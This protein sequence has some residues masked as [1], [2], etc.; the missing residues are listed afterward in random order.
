MGEDVENKIKKLFV[1]T[2]FSFSRTDPEFAEIIANF[3][4]DETVKESTLIEKEQML[5]ILSV[6]LGCQGMGEFQ[7]MLYVALNTGIDPVAIKEVIYQATA[8]LGIGR[9]YDFLNAANQIMEQHGIRLPLVPQATTDENTRF[10]A[11]LDKQV[12]LFG[13]DMAKRQTN[14]PVLCRNINRWLADKAGI[15]DFSVCAKV[16]VSIENMNEIRR[17]NFRKCDIKCAEIWSREKYE[18]KSRWTPSDVKQWRK[19]NGYTWH[20]RNNMVICDLVPTK[21]NRFF[22]HL[23]GVSECKKCRLV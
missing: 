13:P 15:P 2:E 9:T 22:G 4:Q 5:C 1:G 14:G 7:N 18:G 16:T 19:E 20:E 23:G 10:E 17:E 11:G 21:I 12:E 6:L 3:S 8:Y